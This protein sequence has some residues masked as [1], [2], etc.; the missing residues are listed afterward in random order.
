MTGSDSPFCGGLS[1]AWM[2]ELT[3]KRKTATKA[4]GIN[5]L[6][7]FFPRLLQLFECIKYRFVVRFLRDLFYELNILDHSLSVYEEDRP[8]EQS[9]LF[10]QNPKG[11]SER[12]LAVIR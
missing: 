8:C 1:A 2:V 5:F 11:V 10:D 6:F 3:V 7:I 12:T 4:N 9:E